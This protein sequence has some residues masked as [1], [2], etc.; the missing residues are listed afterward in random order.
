MRTPT[1]H[2]IPLHEPFATRLA[3]RLL[4]ASPEG[5]SA[6]DLSGALVVLPSVRACASLRHALLER[7]GRAALLLPDL[8]TPPQL[9]AQLAGRFGQ[10]DA[11]ATTPPAA[12]RPLLLAGRLAALPWV[13]Q[14]GESATGLAE[15]LLRTFDEA[16]LA[17]A[18]WLLDPSAA[19]AAGTAGLAGRRAEL[20]ALD[21]GRLRAAF[22]IYRRI[23]PADDVDVLVDVAARLDRGWPGPAYE[24][25][26]VAGFAEV[27]AVTARI[28][29]AALSA[30]DGQIGLDSTDDG[31]CGALLRT[32]GETG[33]ATH[34]LAPSRRLRIL[35]APG[36]AEPAPSP[37]DA[38]TRAVPELLSCGDPEEESRV[39]AGLVVEELL[40][41]GGNVRIAV[42]TADRALARRV[43]A[44]LRDAGVDVD[45]TGGLP[46]AA[47]SAGRLCHFLLQCAVTGLRHDPLLEVLTHPWVNLLA[48]RG[49]H[50]RRTLL[51]EK[52]VLRGEG[53][54][55][56]LAGYRERAE[57]KDGACRESHGG[58]P[59]G[60]V[61]F[62]NAIGAA[63]APLLDAPPGEA[64]W[65][66]RLAALRDAWAGVAA[67]ASLRPDPATR[68][69]EGRDG[70]DASLVALG[71]LIDRLD[72]LAAAPDALPPVTLE[73]FAAT[74][75]R[76]FAAESVRPHRSPFLP[77]QVMGLIEARLERFD[78]LLIAGANEEVFPGRLRRP[79]FL[80]DAART[81]TGL[82]T[83]RER[84][85]LQGELFLHLLHGAER[86]VVTWARER[87]G[88]PA[89]PSPLVERL[90]LGLGR[91]AQ[92][93]RPG[94]LYRRRAPD[95]GRIRHAQDDF[96]GEPGDDPLAGPRVEARSI[97]LRHTSHSGLE[98]Y[99]RCPYRFL[100]EKGY[101][102]AEQEEVLESFRKLDHGKTVHECLQLFL[103]PD[104]V[105]RRRLAARDRDGS[106]RE[107]RRLAA[108][109]FSPGAGAAPQRGLWEETFLTAAPAIVA[110]ELERESSWQPTALE[111]EF[112]LTLGELR[113]WLVA[114]LE[115][116]GGGS[117]SAPHV[118]PV[119][120]TPAQARINLT[121]WIDRIDVDANG[122]HAAVIDYKSGRVP[123]PKAIRSGDEPQLTLYAVA[124]ETGAV[125]GLESAGLTVTEAGYYVFKRDE[126]GLSPRLDLTD[127]GEGRAPLVAGARRILLDTLGA[128]DRERPYPLLPEFRDGTLHDNLPCPF[129]PFR[130]VCRVDERDLPA[131]L[132]ARLAQS[133][134]SR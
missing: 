23:V 133:G 47:L 26:I 67:G 66:E 7:S 55:A 78:L 1:L 63:L 58:A 112:R 107:L 61:A 118:L 73:E 116:E 45:D 29:R 119:P 42:A 122:K 127:A 74:L 6:G 27:D 5:A 36:A 125:T 128:T 120:L 12:L 3:D 89:L 40:K 115:A 69:D 111:Q 9:V 97:P 90:T 71:E 11:A 88:Q 83:W 106:L 123:N 104:S 48:S 20:H 46:L 101:G 32:Y 22:A 72:H 17:D 87:D 91:T 28:L 37:T 30:S 82:P 126:A 117:A 105:G 77:V 64:P 14:R 62:V 44:Q 15:E 92:I 39:V 114:E 56:G 4:A 33:P 34:P 86:V 129:C 10:D 2:T 75:D 24:R 41:T 84:L 68:N 43:V 113:A 109:Q 134:R 76:L 124:V 60:L 81:A 52:L 85:G 103:E 38:A 100:L 21:L 35:L 121:G 31:L 57:E 79:L 131:P 70:R 53:P 110:H 95:L 80:G 51:L 65:C 94:P 93:A 13:A 102:L 25:V 99:R 98:K 132:R 108:A 96:A 8:L 49:L 130:G 59:T 19:V 54:P 18:G 50:S 16:R